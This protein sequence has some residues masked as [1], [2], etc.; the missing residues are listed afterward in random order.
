MSEIGLPLYV[1]SG[2][3]LVRSPYYTGIPV[4]AMDNHGLK[5]KVRKH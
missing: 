4:L 1:A 2:D 3:G 5:G